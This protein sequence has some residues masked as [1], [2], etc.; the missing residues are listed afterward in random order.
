ML[1]H[2]LRIPLLVYARPRKSRLETAPTIIN[3]TMNLYSFFQ[4][5]LVAFQTNGGAEI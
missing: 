4:V 2:G 3:N 5:Y 1:S